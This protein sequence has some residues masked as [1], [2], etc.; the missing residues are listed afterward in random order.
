MCIFIIM[1]IP[2]FIDSGNVAR[3]LTRLVPT[4]K[5]NTIVLVTNITEVLLL[6]SPLS[7]SLLTFFGMI[8]DCEVSVETPFQHNLSRESLSC[9]NGLHNTRITVLIS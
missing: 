2:V 4:Y 8:E 9:L 1:H 5:S 7:Q 6:S 3:A